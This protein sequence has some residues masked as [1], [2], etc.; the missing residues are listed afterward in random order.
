MAGKTGRF[1]TP[2][3]AQE[4]EPMMNTRL[5]KM[6]V[7]LLA[8]A[9]A[10]ACDDPPIE[11]GDNDPA[12]LFTSS[13]VVVVEAG[14][15]SLVR[16][17][18]VNN[19]GNPLT[20]DV[21]FSACDATISVA[22]DPEQTT[23]EPGSNFIVTGV[24]LGE[25]CVNVSA[26][27]FEETITVR[28]VPAELSVTAAPDT[29]RAGEAGSIDLETRTTAGVFVG[30]FAD[31][32]VTFESSDE[33]RLFFT[34]DAGAFDTDEAGAVTVT[35]TFESFGVQREVEIPI[36]VIPGLPSEGSF[37]TELGA[38]LAGDTVS[39]T[40][41]LRDTIGNVNDLAS[42]IESIVV[43]SSDESIAT[44]FATITENED[45]EGRVILT[46]FAVG[47]AGGQADISAT[48]NTINGAIDAGSSQVTVLDELDVVT[49]LPADAEPGE[50]V[51]ITGTGL[52]QP[53]AETVVLVDGVD[54]TSYV[55][56]ITPTTIT[57]DFP[58]AGEARDMDVTVDVGG[59]ATS[60]TEVY[61]FGGEA[62]EPENDDETATTLPFDHTGWF[63][64]NDDFDFYAF[65]AP[66]TG[67]VNMDLDWNNDDLDLD[68]AMIDADAGAFI[69]TGGA[70]GAKPE[71]DTC[72]LTAGTNYIIY[73]NDY[74]LSHDGDETPVRYHMTV[75]YQ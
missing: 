25:S 1:I 50:T 72:D 19:L 48:V 63:G 33:D 2:A 56:S 62:D 69:C 37:A 46:V 34:D 74:S 65:T 3:R 66:T 32:D 53:G 45:L 20:G 75:V 13:S 49:I 58:G 67:T 24:T 57:L 23:V 71:D 12:R 18:L 7:A 64:F 54:V 60:D 14:A 29:V 40:V 41:Q 47:V 35:A 22:A 55:T 17:H 59:G 15:S 8:V 44:A 5:S 11:P 42:D 21:A 68:M 4:G 51:V 6:L 70:T 61:A 73:I 28:V 38:V 52:Q 36:T 43:T 31:T 26:A 9:T 10:G 39:A 16:A 30:P 27:G